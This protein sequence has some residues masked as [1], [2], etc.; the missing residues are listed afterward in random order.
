MT[1]IRERRVTVLDGDLRWDDPGPADDLPAGRDPDGVLRADRL[2]RATPLGLLV[3][4][5]RTDYAVDAR[6]DRAGP[7]VRRPHR[8]RHQNARLAESTR[9]LAARLRAISDLAGRLNRIQDVAG[10]AEAIVAEARRL[11]DYD[12]IRVYRVDHE[13]GMCEPIAFQGTFVGRRRPRP[14]RRSGSGSARA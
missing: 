13:A 1:A 5:H 10:I 6:R 7:G 4:Y 8:D 9:T 12:T 3:L 11:I 2:P 14:R